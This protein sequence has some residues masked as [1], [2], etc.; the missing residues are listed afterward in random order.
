MGGKLA[1]IAIVAV[2]IFLILQSKYLRICHESWETFNYK[3]VDNHKGY[4]SC[5]CQKNKFSIK[6]ERKQTIYRAVKSNFLQILQKNHF[7][8][9]EGVQIVHFS[10]I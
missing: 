4:K 9:I 2:A 7:F 10:G 3:V 8:Q 5:E 1:K 6:I